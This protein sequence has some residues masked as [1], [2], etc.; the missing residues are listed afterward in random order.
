MT[1]RLLI[2]KNWFLAF[3]FIL[4]NS[5]LKGSKLPKKKTYKNDTEI[6]APDFNR[7]KWLVDSLGC[8]GGKYEE[9]R[10]LPED[11]LFLNKTKKQVL[12]L[13]GYPTI[14]DKNSLVY[15]F[16]FKVEPCD[17][18]FLKENYYTDVLYFIL[19]K[20]K[21]IVVRYLVY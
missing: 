6:Y 17:S 14:C 10:K 5:H 15:K 8:N 7:R 4:S 2:L 11:S 18:S 21:V 16:S 20:D 13:L 1:L 19:K 3:L 12:N 9:V